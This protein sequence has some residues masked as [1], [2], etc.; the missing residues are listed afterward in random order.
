MKPSAFL[1]IILSVSGLLGLLLLPVSFLHGISL[2][3]LSA[4]TARFMIKRNP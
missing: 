1:G 2:L 4:L 3:G